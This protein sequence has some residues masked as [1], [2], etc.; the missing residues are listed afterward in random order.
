MSCVFILWNSN[1]LFTTWQLNVARNNNFQD[2][3]CHYYT[4]YNDKHIFVQEIWLNSG[5]FYIMP[6]PGLFYIMLWPGLFYIMPWPGPFYVMPWPGLF[7]IMPWPGLF[8]IMPWPG[9]FYIMLWPD[10][11]LE[12][13]TCI[14][15]HTIS[16]FVVCNII[17]KTNMAEN[18]F[19]LMLQTILLLY[20]E[21][22]GKT[23]YKNKNKIIDEGKKVE[24]SV[25]W[26]L[27]I[28]SLMTNFLTKLKLL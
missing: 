5:L 14:S 22:N 8:Y 10:M 9:P 21:G 18:D 24:L 3:F 23:W 1:F 13:K 12:C 28:I 16:I 11:D 26:N 27:N 20:F 17:T 2:G 15:P 7:Y 19:L 25:I 4:F 6:W